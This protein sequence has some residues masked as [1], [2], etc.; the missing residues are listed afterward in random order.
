MVRHNS[1]SRIA[2]QIFN[3][4]FLI[5]FTIVCIFPLYYVIVYSFSNPKEAARAGF[6]LWPQGFTFN[7]YTHIFSKLN[8]GQAAYISVSRTVIGTC[9][10][11]VSNA[12]FAYTMTQKRMILKKAIY[13]MVI[14]TMYVSGGLIPS[15]L[16]ITALGLRDNFL[17][18]VIPGAVQA[19]NLIL[20]K[21]YIES[22]PE[23]LEESA[24]ID[25]ANPFLIF[26]KIIFP[27][28]MP[29]VA[30]ISIFGAVGQWNSWWDNFLYVEDPALKTLQL[31]LLEF[32]RDLSASQM[33]IEALQSGNFSVKEIT[34]MSIQM[35]ITIIVTAPIIFVYPF[36]QRYFVKG[37]ML[38]AVKG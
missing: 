5:L 17:V 19:F 9:I 38:G 18:Y 34:P 11:V 37:M 33:S 21:T 13:R 32:L 14:I 24:R 3:Y 23:S 15:Y 22:L 29:I 26:T 25:G 8:L 6:F 4:T 20:V 1:K 36:F 10:M 27:L 35:T 31:T 12:M 2:F 30:T 28:C 7:N 16:L